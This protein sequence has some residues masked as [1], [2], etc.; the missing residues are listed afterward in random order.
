MPDGIVCDNPLPRPN[1]TVWQRVRGRVI[2]LL[3]GDV[4]FFWEPD[5][6]RR[7]RRLLRDLQAGG[8]GHWPHHIRPEW[9]TT[10][11]HTR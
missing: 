9:V 6:V 8:C 2:D 5:R 7:D 3:P 11:E 4:G 1:L 10:I